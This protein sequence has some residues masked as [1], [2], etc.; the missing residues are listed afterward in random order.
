MNFSRVVTGCTEEDASTATRISIRCTCFSTANRR[1]PWREK[2]CRE[3]KERGRKTVDGES[4]IYFRGALTRASRDGNSRAG[5]ERR[6]GRERG[7]F[8]CLERVKGTRVATSAAN[9]VVQLDATGGKE[10]RFPVTRLLPGTNSSLAHPS[11]NFSLFRL[12][13]TVGGES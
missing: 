12:A 3:G 2:G 6:H 13:D 4:R 1:R 10:T 7:E 8:M 9:G 11:A 5:A